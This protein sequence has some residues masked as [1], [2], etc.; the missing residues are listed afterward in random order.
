L[1]QS[2]VQQTAFELITAQ[3]VS[4]LNGPVNFVVASREDPV[5]RLSRTFLAVRL[6]CAQCHDHP[7]DRWTNSDYLAM[8]HFYR[9]TQYREVSGGILVRDSMPDASEPKP[10][11]L[12]GRQPR[13][14]AWRRELAWMVV[15]SKPF[16]RAMVNRTW[17]WLMGRG[18]VEPVDGLS[19]DHPPVLPALLESLS[20]AFRTEEYQLRPLIKQICTSQAYQR[21]PSSRADETS[22]R[23]RALFAARTVRPLLPEQWL[24]SLATVMQQ[25]V[26]PPNELAEQAG[27]LLGLSP[28]TPVSDPYHWEAN[29]QTLIRELSLSLS[30]DVG[31]LDSIYLAT[32]SRK[33]TARERELAESYRVQELFFALVHCNEFLMND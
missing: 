18:I 29:S 32:L 8:K 4:A 33:P 3:G 13:T 1:E 22:D 19:R 26:P 14:S 5:M 16:S 7:H 30:V 21:M 23:Q 2:S 10:V 6:D 31:D 9:P 28:L 12:T 25:P 11:F 24:A 17:F 27:R 20:E 15:Q